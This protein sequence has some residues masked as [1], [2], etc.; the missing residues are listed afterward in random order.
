VTIGVFSSTG[1][2]RTRFLPLINAGEKHRSPGRNFKGCY[3]LALKKGQRPNLGYEG[4]VF[5]T[6]DCRRA[7]IGRVDNNKTSD[8]VREAA[9]SS[10]IELLVLTIDNF[11]KPLT[12]RISQCCDARILTVCVCVC[13]IHL[14]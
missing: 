5:H 9:L 10:W 6:A 4:S 3:N 14:R 11:H 7:D 1:Q 13:V 12:W 2:I 8:P